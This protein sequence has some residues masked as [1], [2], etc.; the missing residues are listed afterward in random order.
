MSS[1]ID[2]GM[3]DFPV[4]LAFLHKYLPCDNYASVPT[5]SIDLITSYSASFWSVK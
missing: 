1:Q 4:R 2:H 5:Y 3:Q